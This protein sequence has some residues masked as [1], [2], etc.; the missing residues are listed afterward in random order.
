MDPAVTQADSGQIGSSFRKVEYYGSFK[1]KAEYNPSI[2][3]FLD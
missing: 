2:P 1:E 3:G